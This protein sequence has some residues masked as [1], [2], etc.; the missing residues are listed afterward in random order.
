MS[1]LPGMTSLLISAYSQGLDSLS[2]IKSIPVANRE[3]I[4]ILHFEGQILL[5]QHPDAETDCSLM[6]MAR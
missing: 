2:F 3:M 6:N 4:L 1:Q 5:T